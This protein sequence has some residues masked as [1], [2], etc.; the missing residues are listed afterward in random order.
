MYILIFKANY[1]LN[2]FTYFDVAVTTILIRLCNV[3]PE[4]NLLLI[5][6]LVCVYIN[7]MLFCS[8]RLFVYFKFCFVALI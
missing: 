6:F 5:F 2:N 7:Y 1:F 3:C 8:C 4:S